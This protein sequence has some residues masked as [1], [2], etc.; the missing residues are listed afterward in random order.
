MLKLKDLKNNSSIMKMQK[1]CI[2][3]HFPLRKE[4]R[5]QFFTVKP[6]GAM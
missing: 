2:T 4:Y 1:N 6:R 5:L 3:L